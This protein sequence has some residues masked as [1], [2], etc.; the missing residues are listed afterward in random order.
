PLSGAELGRPFTLK[1]LGWISPSS[2]R[3]VNVG[4]S[5]ATLKYTEEGELRLEGKDRAGDSWSVALTGA[6]GAQGYEGDVDRNN[7]RDLLLV[8]PTGG[9]GLA[10]SSHLVA[11]TFESDGRPARFEAEGYFDADAKGIFDL[12][13]LNGDGQ[14]ELIYMNFDDGYWITHLY[15]VRA[16]RWRRIRGRFGSRSYPLYTRFTDR[17]NR[18]AVAP[19]PGRRPF[20]PDL[21]NDTASAR[22][23]RL[24]SYRW[25][26]VS[27]S[28]DVELTFET[29]AG[30]QLICRPVSWFAS[31]TVVS[32]RT[33]ERKIFSLAVAAEEVKTALDEIIASGV[34]VEL[35][36]ARDAKNCSPETLWAKMK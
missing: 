15:T 30:Q 25:A 17:P 1:H 35:Y 12:R 27:H 20:A 23:A 13:D 14:A 16:A 8:V 34:E 26:N 11:V 10:P 4:V 33:R 6:S 7:L 36:G 19:R 9:N 22:H 18:R 28:E 2:E 5:S 32:D 21:S 31:F 3:R 29:R 24:R